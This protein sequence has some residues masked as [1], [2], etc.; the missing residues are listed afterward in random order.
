MADDERKLAEFRTKAHDSLALDHAGA[1]VY[2]APTRV[3]LAL[4]QERWPDIRF[5]ETRE[6][7]AA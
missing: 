2:L 1:L 4:T 5:L 3:N 6:H 7:L